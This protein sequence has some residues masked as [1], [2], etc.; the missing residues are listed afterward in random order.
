[1]RKLRV[2]FV[3]LSLLAIGVAFGAVRHGVMGF[4]PLAFANS[5]MD[6]H[7][8]HDDRQV[9]SRDYGTQDFEW[10]GE[11]S[12][13]DVLEVKGV[14]GSVEAGLASG[15][16][17]RVEAEKDGRDAEEVRIEVIEHSGGVTI[18]AIYPSRDDGNYCEPGDGGQNKVRNHRA[19]VEFTVEVPEGVTFVGKTVNGDVDVRG[20]RSDAELT[21]VNGDVEVGTTEGASA[22][23][24]N[25]SIYAELG[26]GWSQDV[27][28]KTV[29]G[30]IEIDVPD[31][32]GA[33]VDASWVNGSL[34]VD[35]PLT[36]QG[37]MQRRSA[38]GTIGGGGPELEVAT[39]NGSIR[40]HE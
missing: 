7:R 40:V 25:G 38:K 31:A 19:S 20:L 24:V 32:A 14:N 21:T 36:L 16:L 17:A 28:M 39:V 6:D 2:L 11:L 27:S 35:S 22:H 4:V 23:T 13:G 1:M 10:D 5:G 3:C 12:P 9:D 26:D 37:R 30:S 29:N 33:D 15:S 18:C 8:D 34:E